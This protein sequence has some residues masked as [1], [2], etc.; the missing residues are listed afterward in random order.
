MHDLADRARVPEG[1]VGNRDVEFLFE[2]QEEV[3][4]CCRFDAE[5]AEDVRV[6]RKAGFDTRNAHDDRAHL[7]LDAGVGHGNATSLWNV[8]QLYAPDRQPR[9]GDFAGLRGPLSSSAW[10]FSGGSTGG[11]P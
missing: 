1:V 6:T 2:G 10:H 5:L 4:R 8:R 11:P 3:Q 9:K 7:L